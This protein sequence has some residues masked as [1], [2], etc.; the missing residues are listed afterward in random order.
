MR[1][2]SNAAKV[3]M[4]G[5]LDAPVIASLYEA[6]LGDAPWREADI[7][8][9]LSGGSGFACLASGRAF[10]EVMPVGFAFGRVSAN[11]SELLAIG[12]L[13][14]ARRRGLGGQLLDAF[15]DASKDRDAKRL[16][17]E[18]RCENNTALSLYASRGLT[19]V[20]QRPAYYR[21]PDGEASDAKVLARDL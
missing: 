7:A 9:L 12:V 13:P 10:G 20:G 8:S 5:P 2:P 14:E 1:K 19:V 18:V 4:A 15:I 11:E 16:F 21:R 6:T 3:V 17:L